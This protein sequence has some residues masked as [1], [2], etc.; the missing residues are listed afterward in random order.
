MKRLLAI[1]LLVCLLCGCAGKATV[2]TESTSEP[3]ETAAPPTELP[4]EPPTEPSTEPPTEPTEPPVLFR[5]PLNGTPIDTPWTAR[6]FAVVVNNI[7]EA[8]PQHGVSQAD[9]IFEILAEGGI[10]RCLALFS[11]ISQVEKLGSLRSARTYLIDLA[12]AHDA[13]FV[14]VGGSQYAYNQLSNGKV[15]HLDARVDSSSAFYRDQARLSAGY[16]YEHTLF[17]SGPA[18]LERVT[19]KGFTLTRE[20]GIEYNYFFDRDI[21][22]DGEAA[23]SIAVKFPGGKTTSM[24]YNSDSDMYEAAQHGGAYIDGN[25]GG[26]MT[27]RNVLVV[28]AKMSSDGYRVFH[29]TVGSGEGYFACG[30]VIVPILWSRADSDSSFNFTLT[31]GTPITLGVGNSYVGIVPTGSTVDYK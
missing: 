5:N 26:V 31:D 19:Q 9:M 11:D 22:L 8:M 21:S 28:F 1:L 24:T 6:P 2:P 10:T 29:E 4:T 12:Q 13:I 14:H 17:T 25:E 7:R 27:F 20:A 18:L 3:T 16:A 15:T 30:G 23:D